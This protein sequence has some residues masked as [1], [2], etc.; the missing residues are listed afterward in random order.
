MNESTS[1]HGAK[2]KILFYPDGK[3]GVAGIVAPSDAQVKAQGAGG[4]LQTVVIDA[5]EVDKENMEA[6]IRSI[7]QSKSLL[8]EKYKEA[9]VRLLDPSGL[10]REF[11]STFDRLLLMKNRREKL[12]GH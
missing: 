9:E 3:G 2:V 6:M 7:K 10:R 11:L 5:G 4:V 8:G 12:G 1:L